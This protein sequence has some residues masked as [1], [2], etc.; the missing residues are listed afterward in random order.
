MTMK[1]KYIVVL[2]LIFG[3]VLSQAQD[4]SVELKQAEASYADSKYDTTALIYQSILEEGFQSPNLYYNLG[5]CY[6]K[7]N[8]IP[9]A[10]LN[11]ERA[12]K[13]DPNNEN[14]LYNLNLCNSLIP[15]R[16]EK[17]PEL[18][19]VQWYKGLY[20]FFPIDVWAKV[21]IGLFVLFTVFML[22]YFLSIRLFWRKMGFWMA[23][24][25]LVFAV[26]SFFLTS[27]KY[28]SFKKH[29]QAIIFTPSITVKSSPA[30]NSVDLFVV[31][32]G[33]KVFI[34][35]QVGEWKKI[36]IQNGS[37]GWVEADNMEII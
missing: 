10:I 16:I 20:N 32:E 2:L 11:Y 29:N 31:H 12:L 15:D 30:K 13:F 25:S 26:F 3:S 34:L 28:S 17:M 5:N 35:D 9:S 4:F 22:I 1:A 24:I 21:V 6:Y 8:E 18:F 23:M 19:F 14:I 7:L 36:K 27:Q 33:T 37:I